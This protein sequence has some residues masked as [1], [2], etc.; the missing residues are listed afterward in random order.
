MLVGSCLFSVDAFAQIGSSSFGAFANSN[1][2]N[3]F[4]APKPSPW[5]ANKPVEAEPKAEIV[6]RIRVDGANVIF[7]ATSV[8]C[9]GIKRKSLSF[10]GDTLSGYAITGLCGELS[11]EGIEEIKK[12][13]FA[14]DSK[15]DFELG[16]C[17]ANPSILIRFT[18]GYDILDLALSSAP[19]PVGKV[20]Y[21][22]RTTSI[23]L[24]PISKWLG[25][26]VAGMN[27]NMK[28]MDNLQQD[29]GD[30]ESDDAQDTPN[31]KAWIKQAP[32]A[33]KTDET[34]NKPAAQP[35]SNNHKIKRSWATDDESAS[36]SSSSDKPKIKRAWDVK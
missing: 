11:K 30:A 12:E 26:F 17:S 35:S 21:A 28:E 3:A 1:A 25:T 23:G 14:K 8:Q 10:D 36:S 29:S 33:V 2:K 27:S 18:R 20:M 24:S 13:I 15:S 22:G 7:K 32:T 9:Y 16:R 19:C 5:S 6:E 31:V 34:S 4:P